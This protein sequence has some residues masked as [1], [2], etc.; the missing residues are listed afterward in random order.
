MRQMR[1]WSRHSN[2]LGMWDHWDCSDILTARAVPNGQPG[3]RLHT[4]WLPFAFY[5][6]KSENQPS[7]HG[8]TTRPVKLG[9]A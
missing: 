6:I 7:A 3:S 2:P 1:E 9:A 8:A 4:D 5:E